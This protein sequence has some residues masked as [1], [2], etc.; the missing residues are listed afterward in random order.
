MIPYD[1]DPSLHDGEPHE[2]LDDGFSP[3]PHHEDEGV[4]HGA[5]QAVLEEALGAKSPF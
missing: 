4:P 5:P 1:I 3:P 2:T